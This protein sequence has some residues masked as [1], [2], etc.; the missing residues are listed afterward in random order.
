MIREGR[1]IA[2]LG[3]PNVGKSS[4]FNQL[5]GADRAIVAAGPG[6]TRDMLRETIDLDGI[7][8]GLVD[9]AGIRASDDEVE[10][11]GVMR[12]RGAAGV[13]DLVVLVLDQS[14]PLEDVDRALMRETAAAP[15]IVVVNK[16]DLPPAWTARELEAASRDS[17]FGIRDSGSQESEARSQKPEERQD[18][19]G[20]PGRSGRSSGYR[21]SR[22]PNPEPRSRCNPGVPE[23]RRGSR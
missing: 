10:R 4:L 17:G 7:R 12:A 5:V 21:E 14:R 11:E 1:Q 23:D 22:V 18:A 9:T 8:L 16:I 13:A 2:I 6:T 3:K 15:R 19:A 20:S